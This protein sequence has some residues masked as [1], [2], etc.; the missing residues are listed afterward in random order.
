MGSIIS[1]IGAILSGGVTGLLGVVF[2]R[3]ADYKN[4]Q[5]DMQIEKQKGDLELLKMDKEAQIR[6]AEIAGKIEVANVETRGASDVAESA[7][8]TKSFEMEPKRY[9]DGPAPA[10][11]AGVI[12][13]LLLTTVDVIRGI[14]R[15]VLTLYLCGIATYLYLDAH[16]LLSAKIFTPE[17]AISIV[18][19]IIDTILY[20]WVTCTTWWFGTRNH[21]P[22]PAPIR[23][24]NTK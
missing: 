24:S 1:G 4:K 3:F 13:Y 15:P 12:S 5:L 11:R 20:L 14:V 7:A 23:V 8:F 6:Q 10:G 17:Q 18:G 19:G 9:A 21:Q 2:Q 16:S 22:A